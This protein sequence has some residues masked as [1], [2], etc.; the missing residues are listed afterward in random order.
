MLENLLMILNSAA[1]MGLGPPPG[2]MG[3]QFETRKKSAGEMPGKI[4]FKKG[5]VLLKPLYNTIDY[6]YTQKNI[7]CWKRTVISV[8]GLEAYSMTVFLF[9]LM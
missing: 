1:A 3:K 8:N 5:L 9:L 6:I 4:G 7:F 2:D